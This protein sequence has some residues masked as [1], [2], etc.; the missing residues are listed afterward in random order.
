MPRV[1]TERA[2]LK[3]AY[4][5][6]NAH[7][8]LLVLTLFPSTGIIFLYR[9][10]LTDY[11]RAR[12][13][14]LYTFFQRSCLGVFIAALTLCIRIGAIRRRQRERERGIA[15]ERFSF[16]M[17]SIRGTSLLLNKP[18]G[19]AFLHK[20]QCNQYCQCSLKTRLGGHLAALD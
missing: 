17:L 2:D 11:A 13:T 7:R 16:S 10:P 19:P 8:L 18:S 6:G 12:I 3:N 1:L 5:A 15:A 20:P 9:M 14:V 4:N